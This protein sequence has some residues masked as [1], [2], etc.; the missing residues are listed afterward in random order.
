MNAT[1]EGATE[2]AKAILHHHAVLRGGLEERVGVLG[3]AVEH[4]TAYGEP[5]TVLQEYLADEIMP[6]AE[7][8]ERTLY[9]AAVTQAR[10]S[11]LVGTLTSEHRELAGLVGRLQSPTDGTTAAATAESFATLFA[12]H[13]A[14]ENDLLLP[15]LI[16]SG[17]NL[18]GLLAGA[19]P[20]GLA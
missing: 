18:A 9:R 14:K 13:V 7:W 19:S 10:G 1:Y 8:V 6:H 5:L 3:A 20:G 12:D 15:A 4:G 11:Q 2:Q 16:D 17:V